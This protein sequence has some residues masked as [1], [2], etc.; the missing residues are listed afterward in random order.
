MP[1]FES[2]PRARFGTS[3]LEREVSSDPFYLEPLIRRVVTELKRQGYLSRADEP[4]VRLGL[5][6]A[7][8][9]AIVHGNRGD[10]AK[11]LKVRV[12]G[13]SE[14]WAAEI[15][16]EGAGMKPER[17][18]PPIEDPAQ[19]KRSG[20]GIRLLEKSFDEVVYLG[21]GNVVLV[22][23]TR[24]PADPEAVLE[25]Q[26]E[27]PIQVSGPGRPRPLERFSESDSAFELPVVKEESRWP[28]IE[29]DL[30]DSTEAVRAVR[31]S[32]ALVIEIVPERLS[33]ENVKAVHSQLA[34]LAG[35]EPLVVVDFRRVSYISSVVLGSLVGFVDDVEAAGGKVRL[36]SLSPWVHEVFDRAGVLAI[37]AFY[38]DPQAAIASP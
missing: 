33:D 8:H 36:S 17:V 11:K 34:R 25:G 29:G 37:F 9:N 22:A 24:S 20:R 26:A 19:R 27:A 30:V 6:E 2:S 14:R 32:G 7:I 4:G 13:D 23:R 1:G 28:R 38:P 31:L 10:A 21:R 12:Y 5:D 3:L 15:E 18:P 16:D 35:G